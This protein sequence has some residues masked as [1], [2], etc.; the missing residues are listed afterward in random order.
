MN[1]NVILV[2]KEAKEVCDKILLDNGLPNNGKY[3]GPKVC[4][5]F[6]EGDDDI[7][8]AFDNTNSDMWVEEFEKESDAIAWCNGDDESINAVKNT[9]TFSKEILADSE[10]EAKEIFHKHI[11]S[12]LSVYENVSSSFFISES[13]PD[14]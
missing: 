13:L 10:E 4:G 5:Y 3:K 7:I 6:V 8:V 12:A 14:Y 9:Y 11:K 1:S 2:G